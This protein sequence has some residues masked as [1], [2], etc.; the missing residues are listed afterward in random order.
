MEIDEIRM[1]LGRALAEMKRR[2]DA[3]A[4]ADAH[5]AFDSM[6]P[7]QAVVHFPELAASDVRAAAEQ[8]ARLGRKA[9]VSLTV[10]VPDPDRVMLSELGGSDLLRQSA[11]DGRSVRL[12]S[13]R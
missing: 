5:E 4:A 11:A 8:I 10:L 3:L 1:T 2:N 9:R 12:V 7:V 13:E 6:R